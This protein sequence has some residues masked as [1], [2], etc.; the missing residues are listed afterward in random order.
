[1]RSYL[2]FFAILMVAVALGVYVF[3]PEYVEKL[4]SP[5]TK[6]ELQTAGAKIETVAKQGFSWLEGKDAAQSDAAKPKRKPFVPPS[7]VPQQANWTW[8]TTD[9]K[10]YQ[11]VK[12]VKIEADC[13]TILHANG[14]ARIDT[15]TLPAHLQSQ[16]NYDPAMAQDASAQRMDEMMYTKEEM[17]KE[18]AEIKA[19][20]L[21]AALVAH[22]APTGAVDPNGPVNFQISVLQKQYDDLMAKAAVAREGSTSGGSAVAEAY[23]QRAQRILT[24]IQLWK[25]RLSPTASP[26]P[27]PPAPVTNNSAPGP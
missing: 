1:M 11:N 10:V 24:R 3:H 4:K 25:T 20:E 12:I 5:E 8:V 2:S 21:N 9:G 18:A 7:P 16:L 22:A 26:V 23:E 6:Q 14:G 17:D 19:N 15:S 27:P 13:V